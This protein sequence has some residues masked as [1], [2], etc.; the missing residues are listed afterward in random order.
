[1]DI[2]FASS[3]RRRLVKKEARKGRNAD[4]KRKETTNKKKRIDK[5]ANK[6]MESK[7][8]ELWMMGGCM[9]NGRDIR[10]S[11]EVGAGTCVWILG[12]GCRLNDW[13]LC[14]F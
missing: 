4:W 2:K 5:N 7:K 6:L 8:K 12:T 11:V 1:M 3:I 10:N 13:N 14:Y 9:D